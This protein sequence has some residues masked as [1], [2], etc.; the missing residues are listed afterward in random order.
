MAPNDTKSHQETTILYDRTAR[1]PLQADR[2]CGNIR[3]LTVLGCQGLTLATRKHL[4]HCFQHTPA[5][6]FGL[7]VL[8]MRHWG[9]SA[10]QQRR[11][12][13]YDSTFWQVVNRGWSLGVSALQERAV[14]DSGHCRAARHVQWCAGTP[15]ATLE[16][17]SWT[18]RVPYWSHQS[19]P[20]ACP[21]IIYGGLGH[22]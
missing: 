9:G 21:V 16:T 4:V 11:K 10:G 20:R 8:H 1:T 13:C 2:D 15:V 6:A 3:F 12:M 5:C 18:T 17:A 19:G 7:A 22:S 14:R